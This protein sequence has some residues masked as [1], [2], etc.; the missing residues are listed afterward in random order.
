MKT[1][2]EQHLEDSFDFTSFERLTATGEAITSKKGKLLYVPTDI[3]V[4]FDKRVLNAVVD[5]DEVRVLPMPVDEWEFRETVYTGF[6]Y[7]VEQGGEATVVFF[8]PRSLVDNY[9]DIPGTEFVHFE[10]VELEDPT[11]TIHDAFERGAGA[12][13]RPST[14]DDLAEYTLRVFTAAAT[15]TELAPTQIQTSTDEQLDDF[16]IPYDNLTAVPTPIREFFLNGIGIPNTNLFDRLDTTAQ[17]NVYITQLLAA[18]GDRFAENEPK[19]EVAAEIQQLD[20]DIQHLFRRLV[21]KW[22]AQRRLFTATLPELAD[23]ELDRPTIDTI[24]DAY[25]RITEDGSTLNIQEPAAAAETLTQHF[26]ILF[27]NIN[28]TDFADLVNTARDQ[29]S[30]DSQQIEDYSSDQAVQTVD[31]VDTLLDHLAE[32]ALIKHPRFVNAAFPEER[33]SSILQQFVRVAFDNDR[34]DLLTSR[35]LTVLNQARKQERREREFEDQAETVRELDVNLATLPTFLEQWTSYL[36]DTREDN[37]VSPLLRQELI[38]KYDEFCSEVVT[39]YRDIVTDD[40][41]LHLSDLLTPQHDDGVT[42]TVIIDS[43]GYTDYLL[44]NQ[45]GFFD[46]EP[47]GTDLVFSN[48]PSYTPSAITTIFTGLPAEE[49]GIYSWEPRHDNRIYNLKHRS[50]DT[51][52]GFIDQQ[53]ENSFHLIQR[54]QLNE[55]GITR[56]ADEISDIR[57]SSDTTIETD[58][59]DAVREGFVDELEATL[60]ERRRVLEGDEFDPSPEAREAQKSHIVLYLEDFDQYLHETLA[61]AEFENYYRT[62]GT[63]L[64]DLLADIQDTVDTAINETAEINITSDHGKLTRYEMEM[65]LDEH[66]EYEF[67]QQMLTDSIMLDQAYEVNFRQAEFTNRSDN[68]YLTVA[69]DDTDPPVDQVRDMLTEEDAADVSDEELRAIIDKVDYLQSGSKFAFGSTNDENP[70]TDLNQFDSIDSY[71]PRGDGIFTLPDIGLVS[72]YDI[73]NRSG[74]DHGYHGGTSLSEMAALRLTFQGA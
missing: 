28:E 38:D 46:P 27:D 30:S 57:L 1:E 35:Y 40:D 37:D 72:R 33:W 44:L 74:H 3:P 45:F 12:E 43:F 17:Q 21:V 52:Y 60:D 32:V 9:P 56:V 64:T 66:P 22:L 15:G 53:T 41:W 69:T 47:D 13:P 51:D 16:Y 18:Y 68:H 54:P 24:Q 49:T 29:L 73:K 11:R 65:V 36:V 2:L 31:K 71:Q 34:D 67:T 19:Y 55:S 25:Q 23:M 50:P 63:F 14:I 4:P 70:V 39:Q 10:R 26:G 42:I 7:L 59:L 62:L 58:H 8:C 48:I 6:E 20:P 61:F 5:S